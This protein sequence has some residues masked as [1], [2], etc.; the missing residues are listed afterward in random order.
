MIIGS[1]I[2]AFVKLIRVHEALKPFL[3]GPWMPRFVSLVIKESLRWYKSSS[4]AV[5]NAEWV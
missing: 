2:D 5:L 4:M 1:D 3:N